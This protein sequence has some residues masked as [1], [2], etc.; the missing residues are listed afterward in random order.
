MA[1]ADGL[2]PIRLAGQRTTTD[3]R[4]IT[5]SNLVYMFHQ[6]ASCRVSLD[7]YA[8]FCDNHWIRQRMAVS[9]HYFD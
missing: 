1:G 3:H 5:R 7:A 9:H 8:A 2:T 4:Q 6:E